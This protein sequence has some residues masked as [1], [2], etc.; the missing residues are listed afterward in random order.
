MKKLRYYLS[1]LGFITCLSL[2]SVS[3]APMVS[4]GSNMDLFFNGSGGIQL[5]DNL[6]L[7]E[8][9]EVSDTIFTL[10]PGIELDIGRGATN[11]NLNV[12]YQY[13]IR[14][15]SS[16]NQFDNELNTFIVSG[17]YAGAKFEGTAAYSFIQDQSNSQSVNIAGSLIET[18]NVRYHAE[19][20]YQFSPKTSVRVGGTFLDIAYKGGAAPV[21]P[22]RE[23]IT[24]PVDFYYAMT[25]KL[26][27]GVGYVYRDTTIEDQPNAVRN[28]PLDHTVR[29]NLRGELTPK[30]SGTVGLGYQ[31]RE[32]RKGNLDDEGGA[33]IDVDLDWEATP[34]FNVGIGIFSDFNSAGTG[35]SIQ[36]VGF[37]LDGAYAMNP[38]WFLT[39]IVGYNKADYNTSAREDDL[40]RAGIGINWVPNDYVQ[41][42]AAYD[43]LENDSN[44]TGASWKNNTLGLTASLRY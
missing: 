44:L 32:F 7:D 10:K 29:L 33:S 40:W 37:N 4:I 11:A 2:F 42:R 6:T 5:N 8:D 38:V 22:D 28:N 25:P 41:V 36:D 30:L 9:G 34:K 24:V 26:D 23:I 31:V 17:S 35:E 20:E 21:L 27:V 43:Y 39:G 12:L 3:G 16:E 18:D 15:F 19:G 14:R 1:V 13:D